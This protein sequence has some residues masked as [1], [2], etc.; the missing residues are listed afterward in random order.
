VVD[1]RVTEKLKALVITSTDATMCQRELQQAL[2]GKLVA[3]RSLQALRMCLLVG[4]L[5]LGCP[6]TKSR[7]LKFK[8]ASM[9]PAIGIRAS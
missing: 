7:S 2:V 1:D 5:A 9:R 6:A 8:T 4:H 3:Q